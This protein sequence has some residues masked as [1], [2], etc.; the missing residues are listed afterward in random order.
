MKFV[1]TNPDYEKSPYTGM[2]REHWLDACEFLL[3]GI[4]SN[5][6]SAEDMPLS[7]RVEFDIS[8]PWKNGSPTKIYAERFEGLARSFLI[9]APLLR[10]RPD[11]V[12]RGISVAKYYKDLILAAV[13]KDSGNYLLGWKELK[14]RISSFV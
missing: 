9:A 14:D 12:I 1:V 3:D 7:P 6:S 10:S 5:L 13:T 8:Y 11:C 2:T 4:F